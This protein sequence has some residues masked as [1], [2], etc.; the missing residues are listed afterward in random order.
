MRRSRKLS[1]IVLAGLTACLVAACRPVMP[2]PVVAATPTPTQTPP[3]A[4]TAADLLAPTVPP[5]TPSGGPS[6][7]SGYTSQEL[8]LAVF[9]PPGWKASE[10]FA[11]IT[12]EGPDGASL[13]VSLLKEDGVIGQAM[14]YTS[15]M[16]SADALDAI[17]NTVRTGPNGSSVDI[18]PVE[19]RDYDLGSASA[20]Q[21][22]DRAKGEGSYLVVF[23]FAESA[24]LFA[25]QGADRESW[26]SELIP[27]YD[28]I[29]AAARLAG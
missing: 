3:P 6:G 21:V 23:G 28:Q 5:P 25:G 24:L 27:L 11:V 12:L 2:G 14:G 29:I 9:Y 13:T 19:A 17:L 10:A 4:P 20:A 26:Q 15:G 18:G 7:W 22:Y 16:S 1:L 8:G